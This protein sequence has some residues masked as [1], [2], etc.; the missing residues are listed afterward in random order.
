MLMRWLIVHLKQ[1][2]KNENQKI[3]KPKIV[4]RWVKARYILT[5]FYSYK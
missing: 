5:C 2:G 1:T 3:K 4:L